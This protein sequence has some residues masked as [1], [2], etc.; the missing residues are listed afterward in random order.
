MFNVSLLLAILLSLNVL[1]F[2]D[3]Y[4]LVSYHIT[5]DVVCRS[6]LI[7][8]EQFLDFGRRAVLELH[9]QDVL[10]ALLKFFLDLA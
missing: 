7:L 3:I 10:F 9:A 6:M 4:E 8:S 1:L 2:G 5:F